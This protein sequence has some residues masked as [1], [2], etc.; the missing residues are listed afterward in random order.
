MSQPP[1][2]H[3]QYEEIIGFVIELCEKEAKLPFLHAGDE[4]AP[5]C[6]MIEAPAK[7]QAWE[8]PAVVALEDR[9]PPFGKVARDKDGNYLSTANLCPYCGGF[10]WVGLTTRIG[11]IIECL[12]PRCRARFRRA[13]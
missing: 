5:A 4:S 13:I 6:E 10:V 2:I 8:D 7:F 9:T 3:D 1:S 12:D 11:A